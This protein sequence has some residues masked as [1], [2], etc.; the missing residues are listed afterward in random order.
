MAGQTAPNHSCAEYQAVRSG[1]TSC[2]WPNE[3]GRHQAN[4]PLHLLVA[5]T[6]YRQL[7][8]LI[9]RRLNAHLCQPVSMKGDGQIKSAHT[10]L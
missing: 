9:P 1:F 6:S 10:T 2:F 3:S 8:R 7:P 4:R 5:L